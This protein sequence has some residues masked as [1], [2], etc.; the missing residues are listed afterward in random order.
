[1]ASVRL[2]PVA[3]AM[4]L[5]AMSG[6][7]AFTCPPLAEGAEHPDRIGGHVVRDALVAPLAVSAASSARS[8]SPTGRAPWGPSARRASPVRDAREP[9]RHRPR[10]RPP[11]SLPVRPL[12]AEGPAAPPGAPRQPHRPGQ[13]RP[14]RRAARCRPARAGMPDR[15]RWC[16]SSTSTT[17]SP[18]TTRWAMRRGRCCC[19]RSPTAIRRRSARPTSRSALAGDEFAVL[20]EDGRDIGAVIRIAERVIEAV[21]R[22]GGDRRQLGAASASVGIAA[23]RARRQTADELLHD[24]DV[25]MYAAKGRGKGRF[26]VFDPEARD[27]A[28]PSASGCATTSPRRSSAASSSLRYQPVTDAAQRCD[29][30]ARGAPAL[31]P[32]VR[33]ELAPGRVP[34]A[35]GGDRADRAHRPLGAA[36]GM[37]D[38]ARLGRSGRPPAPSVHVNVSVRQLLRAGFVDDVAGI[39]ASTAACAPER[40]TL[41]LREGQVMT[42]D[43]RIAPRLH[44]LKA[45]GVMLAIDGFGSGFSSVRYL[46]RY[47]VDVVKIARPV[48]GAMAARRRMRAS[49][50]RSWSRWGGRST[51]G[52]RRGHRVARPAGARPGDGMRRR[53]GILPRRADGGVGHRGA[54]GPRG[55]K[56]RGSDRGIGRVGCARP[57]LSHLSR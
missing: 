5:R 11:G 54:A 22:A 26:A 57:T 34:G 21:G 45:L 36:R 16:C 46:G 3:D 55:A 13:P 12:R 20:V 53:P 44:A 19:A 14:A 28:R 49:P 23:A 4:R 38:R 8:W 47:P 40:L 39:L 6:G 43:P 33:G 31:G 24:A 50:R 29:R 7:V 30:G 17:S 1:M 2:D 56:A 18:S 42:D 48:V 41:E 25:A 35:R 32:P 52:G 10:E 51:C 37:P 9:C 27:R 15:C